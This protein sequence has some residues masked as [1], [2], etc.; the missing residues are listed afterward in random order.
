M[1]RRSLINK[2]RVLNAEDSTT[3]PRSTETD[4]SSVDKVSY[5]ISIDNT[6]NA[7]AKVKFYNDKTFVAAS[8]KELDFQQT[9]SLNGASETDYM[10]QIENQGFK[11][12]FLDITNNGGTGN[13][14][15]WISGNTVGA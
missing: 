15:A 1:G 14:S 4:V 5:Q 7:I 8:A 6:V 9:L 10:I 13:I 12:L 3:N 11:W 2:F